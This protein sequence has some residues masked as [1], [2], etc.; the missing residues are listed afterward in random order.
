MV[1]E[2]AEQKDKKREMAAMWLGAPEGWG[3]CPYVEDYKSSIK[4]DMLKKEILH[5]DKAYHDK[6][7]RQP[8]KAKLLQ[9]LEENP[10]A[11]KPNDFAVPEEEEEK[12]KSS[13]ATKSPAFTDD[14]RV[15]L[16]HCIVEEH[17][18]AFSMQY[19]HRSN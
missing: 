12:G 18:E 10:R 11:Q 3:T 7:P 19:H 5:R 14:E 4:V 2:S 13:T 16:F 1:K 9:W 15:R 6:L 8:K 17:Y